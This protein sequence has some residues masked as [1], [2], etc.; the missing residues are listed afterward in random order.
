MDVAMWKTHDLR[1]VDGQRRVVA[2]TNAASSFDDQ[3]VGNNSGRTGREALCYV[4]GRRR[5]DRP[6]CSQFCVDEGGA[7][8]ADSAQNLGEC[9]HA[10]EDVPSRTCNATSCWRR[11]EGGISVNSFGRPIMAW[12]A[13]RVFFV[14]PR[15][16]M[17]QEATMNRTSVFEIQVPLRQ[18]YKANPKAALV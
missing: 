11:G 6:W 8:K 18:R 12:F 4:R 1:R 2:H 16:P 3:M 10:E 13:D 14:P 7:A 9:I 5:L 17:R 15:R